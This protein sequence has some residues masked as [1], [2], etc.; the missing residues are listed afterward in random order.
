[1]EVSKFSGKPFSAWQKGEAKKRPFE[2]IKIGLDRPREILYERI[3]SR[4]DQMIE[5]GLESEVRSVLHFRNKNA[6]QTVAYKEFFD[7]FDGK[8]PFN[9]TVNLIKQNTRRYAKRQLTWFKNQ[10]DFQWFQADEEDKI[11]EFIKN[12]L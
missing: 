3:N 6:L 7:Y 10:D 2:I 9:E 1:M 4:V 11:E 5:Q 12:S 8:L